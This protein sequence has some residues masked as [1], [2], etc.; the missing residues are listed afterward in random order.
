LEPHQQLLAQVHWLNS[1]DE[2]VQPTIELAFHSTDYSEQHLGVLFGVNQRIDVPVG[3]QVRADTWC[4]MPEGAKLHAMMGHFHKHGSD[5]KVT[6]RRQDETTGTVIYQAKDE[7]TFDFKLWNP[8]HD[9][10]P[11]AGLEYG[12]TFTNASGEELTWGSDTE[13]QEHCNMTAYYAPAEEHKPTLCLLAPSK[14]VALTPQESSVRAGGEFAFAVELASPETTD[15]AVAIRTT[16]ATALDV[17]AVVVIPA[18][19]K[20]AVFFGRALR[21]APVTISASLSGATVQTNIRVTGLMISEVFY[22]SATGGSTDRMQWI[23]IANQTDA[24]IDLSKYSLGAGTTD[25]MTTRV[26]LPMM[27][28]ARGCVVVGGPDSNAVNHLPAINLAVDLTPDLG[29]GGTQAQGIGL[30]ATPMSS[31]DPSSRPLD[32]VVYAG[33][34]SSLRGPDGQIA[35]VWPG[36]EPGGSLRRVNDSVWSRSSIPTPGTCEVL[37]AH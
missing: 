36:A 4:P 16:D 20:E 27:I 33:P 37:D 17:P 26:A 34:N 3:Q 32:T 10:A 29:I 6:E 7:P 1:T 35:P 13:K 28:P 21:P 24:P 14:L 18:G 23:E 9:V 8:A 5:Y 11:K 22:Q 25:F 31:L 12:C 2:P 19:Q 15:V 30:F